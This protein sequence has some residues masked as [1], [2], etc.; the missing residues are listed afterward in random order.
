LNYNL[1]Q[2]KQL[3]MH[4]VQITPAHQMM[5]RIRPV[6]YRKPARHKPC[7]L[8]YIYCRLVRIAESPTGIDVK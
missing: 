6:K 2:I 7:G 3:I 1:F 5:I 8:F 4:P